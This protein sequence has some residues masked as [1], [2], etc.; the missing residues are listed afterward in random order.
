MA[1]N[2]SF[3]LKAINLPFNIHMIRF[4]KKVPSIRF[5]YI[6]LFSFIQYMLIIT[7]VLADIK[8]QIIAI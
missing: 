7:G 6:Y 1:F 4:N 3:T 2:V 5:P 8:C